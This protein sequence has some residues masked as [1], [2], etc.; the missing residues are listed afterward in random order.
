MYTYKYFIYTY[1]YYKCV[2]INNMYNNKYNKIY[3]YNKMPIMNGK[4]FTQNND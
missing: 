4:S 1:K 3:T 2:D